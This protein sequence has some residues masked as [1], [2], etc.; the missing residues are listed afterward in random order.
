MTPTPQMIPEEDRKLLASNENSMEFRF[1][2]FLN[3]LLNFIYFHQLN[4][5]LNQIEEKIHWR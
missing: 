5:E 2:D 1:Q 3:F 4:D